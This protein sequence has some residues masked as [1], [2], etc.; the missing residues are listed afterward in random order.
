MCL[1]QRNLSFRAIRANCLC[2][3][4]GYRVFNTLLIPKEALTC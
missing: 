4:K 3:V 1:I 2:V